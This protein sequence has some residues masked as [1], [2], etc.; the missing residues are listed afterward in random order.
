MTYFLTASLFFC[1]G[2]IFEAILVSRKTLMYETALRDIIAST[3]PGRLR[4]KSGSL[5]LDDSTWL[6]IRARATDALRECQ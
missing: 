4:Q 3:E 1:L 2:I 5:W 6:R